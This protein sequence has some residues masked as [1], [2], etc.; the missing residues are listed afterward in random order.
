MP[1]FFHRCLQCF[2]FHFSNRVIRELT[3]NL[4][5]LVNKGVHHKQKQLTGYEGLVFLQGQGYIY[6]PIGGRCWQTEAVPPCSKT[7]LLCCSE[8]QP[9]VATGVGLFFAVYN[10]D[11]VVS[12]QSTL[13]SLALAYAKHSGSSF[14]QP[15]TSK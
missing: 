2:G 15:N 13:P 1:A 4:T 11:V 8:A 7:L 10:I 3:N 6:R 12:H 5:S 9:K 14:N